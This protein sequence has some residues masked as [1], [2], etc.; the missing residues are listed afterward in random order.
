MCGLARYPLSQGATWTVQADKQ[1]KAYAHIIR[2]NMVMMNDS[3][4]THSIKPT[5]FPG[6]E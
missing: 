2:I 4:P 3:M 6:Y 5:L 1:S